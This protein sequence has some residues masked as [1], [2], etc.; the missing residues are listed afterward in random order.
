MSRALSAARP[1]AAGEHGAGVRDGGPSGSALENRTPEDALAAYT[2]SRLLAHPDQGLIENRL[3]RSGGFWLTVGEGEQLGLFEAEELQTPGGRVRFLMPA[4]YAARF[5]PPSFTDLKTVVALTTHWATLPRLRRPEGR[6]GWTLS[7]LHHLLGGGPEP[8]GAQLERV[9]ASL[10]RLAVM[11]IERPS[12]D[13]VGRPTREIRRVVEAASF[14]ADQ[15]PGS[16]RREETGWVRFSRDY[17]DEIAREHWTYALDRVALMSAAPAT[18]RLYLFLAAQAMVRG[19]S[20]GEASVY[21]FPCGSALYE[22]LGLREKRGRRARSTI[23]AAAAALES[24]DPAYGPISLV[25]DRRGGWTLVAERR[26]RRS[27][28]PEARAAVLRAHLRDA[29]PEAPAAAARAEER[30]RPPLRLLPPPPSPAGRARV[31]RLIAAGKAALRAEGAWRAT[32]TS[33][34]S[35]P[36]STTRR[37]P[38]RR[39]RRA[40][41]LSPSIDGPPGERPR[42]CRAAPRPAPTEPCCAA[43]RRPPAGR[44]RL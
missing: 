30:P 20:R 32:P 43:G 37:S 28:A 42:M 27:L 4:D 44:R 25:R 38:S 2:R 31:R 33:P 23:A 34:G 1:P 8:S 41:S 13:G 9:W 29:P 26:N 10:N 18:A 6:V 11:A 40:T 17:L 14:T 12:I 35:A 7:G 21:R 3:A 16:G 39:R 19:T 36:P 22:N 5:G 24:L 15:R